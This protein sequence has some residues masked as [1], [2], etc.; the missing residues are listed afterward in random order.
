ML[1]CKV[2]LC[3]LFLCCYWAGDLVQCLSY[4]KLE[5]LSLS[6]PF[7]REVDEFDQQKRTTKLKYGKLEHTPLD[8]NYV[9]GS[10]WPKPQEEHR[11]DDYFFVDHVNF[12]FSANGAGKDSEILKSALK[13]YKGLLFPKKEGEQASGKVIRELVVNVKTKQ[14][15]LD[16]NMD[17]SYELSVEAPASHLSANTIWGTLRGLETFS[18]IIYINKNNK[19]LARKT[20]VKDWPRFKHRGFLIDTSRHYLPL[21]TLYKFLDAM[22]Y[23]KFNV[24]HWHIVD[25][26]AFPYVSK[27]FPNLSL[28]GARDPVTHV[29]TPDNVQAIIS[30]ARNRGIRIIPEFDTPGHTQSWKAIDGL[31]TDCENGNFG[32]IDPTKEANY[33]FLEK[34]FQEVAQVFPDKYLHLGADEVDFTC[35]KQNKKIGEWM[36]KNNNETYEQLEQYY[37]T[38]LVNIIEKL[39][40]KSIVW[41]DI[42]DNGVEL[43]PG[44]LVNLWLP[45]WEAEMKKVTAKGHQVILSSCW[46][47]NYINYGMDWPEY[48]FCDPHDFDGT[49]Q[50]KDLVIGGTAAMWGEYVDS[51]NIL[52]RTW[53]RGLAVGERLWS[54]KSVKDSTDAMQRIWEHRCRYISRGIPAEPVV[55]GK[56]CI[57]EWDP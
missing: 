22:A 53:A 21:K 32:P 38:R 49:D 39:K 4:T 52:D 25:D 34:L 45:G 14:E 6:E 2:F 37:A 51:T 15:N 43:K 12:K 47:L 29:Y 33:K 31:L 3:L 24:L 36:K 55:K 20:K 26:P 54:A 48:Y 30:Y 44:T 41:Q 28:K 11:E 50:E 17:E 5:E 35:W 56:F 42:F 27:T 8:D 16:I 1:S 19:Y 13:R 23:S 10:I 46:Y 18:Q 57:D 9:K 40:R 7:E